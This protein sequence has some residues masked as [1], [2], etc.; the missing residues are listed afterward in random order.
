MIYH[1]LL[2]SATY[3]VSFLQS[4]YFHSGSEGN[5]LVFPPAL[6]NQAHALSVT[7]PQR[8]ETGISVAAVEAVLF[9]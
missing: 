5:F 7:V 6:M 4:F 1:L 3:I 9:V 8:M 2:L